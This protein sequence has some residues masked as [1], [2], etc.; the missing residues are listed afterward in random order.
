MSTQQIQNIKQSQII[1]HDAEDILPRIKG[2]KYVSGS[3]VH[4]VEP[5]VDKIDSGKILEGSTYKSTGDVLEDEYNQNPAKKQC[6]LSYSLCI[7]YLLL[8]FIIILAAVF[9]PNMPSV[10][11]MVFIALAILIFLGA[12]C[13]LNFILQSNARKGKCDCP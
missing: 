7:F 13:H 12:A 8:S 4:V 5:E 9:M 1:N 3:F 6:V 10:N 2:E 11:R